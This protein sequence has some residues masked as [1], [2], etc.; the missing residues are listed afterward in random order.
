MASTSATGG[1]GQGMDNGSGGKDENYINGKRLNIPSERNMP[2]CRPGSSGKERHD[3]PIGPSCTF[4][5]IPM[6]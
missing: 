1:T 2:S 3:T 5:Y 6:P 4:K